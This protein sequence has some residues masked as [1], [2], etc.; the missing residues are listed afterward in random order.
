MKFPAAVP[1]IPAASV[2]E[3]AP[4]DV[5]TLGSSWVQN[6]VDSTDLKASV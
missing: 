4:Y 1:E 6:N 3:A 2:D 5:K